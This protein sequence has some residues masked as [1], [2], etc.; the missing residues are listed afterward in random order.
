LIT[1]L[2]DHHSASPDHDR[3]K[4][5][6]SCLRSKAATRRSEGYDTSAICAGR[7]RRCFSPPPKRSART[8]A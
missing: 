3:R 1:I 2:D 8:S 7:L 5:A 6:A 4:Q